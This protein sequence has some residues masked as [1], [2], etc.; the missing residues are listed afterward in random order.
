MTNAMLRLGINSLLLLAVLVAP[1]SAADKWVITRAT[2]SGACHIQLETSKPYLGVLIPGTH[3]SEKAACEKAK[4]LKSDDVTNS[5]ACFSYTNG[6]TDNC[7]AKGI[8]LP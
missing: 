5:A 1:A 2:M 8:P 3:A 7:K 6:A 4:A